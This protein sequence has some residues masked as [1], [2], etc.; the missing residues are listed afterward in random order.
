[1]KPVYYTIE[2]KYIAQEYCSYY[3]LR[4]IHKTIAHSLQET[5]TLSNKSSCPSMHV[6]D[7]SFRSTTIH[8]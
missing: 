4:T 6:N 5:P 1:M 8:D 3:Y 2:N 7:V